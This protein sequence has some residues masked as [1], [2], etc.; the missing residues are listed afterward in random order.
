MNGDTV[1]QYR[2]KGLIGTG[3]MG[4]VYEAEHTLLGRPAAVKVLLP[5]YSQ[6]QSIV[7]RF[8]S[9]KTSNGTNGSCTSR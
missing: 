9:R 3:G 4:V 7:A 6:N 5:Q 8:F 2:I 1:G